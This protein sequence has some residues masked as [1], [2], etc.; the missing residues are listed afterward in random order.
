[1]L[2]EQTDGSCSTLRFSREAPSSSS[3]S[4]SRRPK[5]T[6]VAKE[7]MRA[8]KVQQTL[9]LNLLLIS[10]ANMVNWKL[11]NQAKVFVKFGCVF[12][13][14]GKG[15]CA[16]MLRCR[17]SHW[18]IES[19]RCFESMGSVDASVEGWHNGGCTPPPL[20]CFKTRA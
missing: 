15:I 17:G 13:Q 19:K 2:M 10:Q 12:I 20:N 16:M 1:M 3:T 7:R 11:A 8:A 18:S 14:V 5:C 6:H 4:K 9:H